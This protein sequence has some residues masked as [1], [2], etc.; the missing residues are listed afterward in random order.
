M[1]ANEHELSTK[2]P[3]YFASLVRAVCT[4]G[5]EGPTRDFYGTTTAALT[6]LDG[7]SHLREVYPTPEFVS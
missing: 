7:A 1:D 4:C 3:S 6:Q 2:S 5:W